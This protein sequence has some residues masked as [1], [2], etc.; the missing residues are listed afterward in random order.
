MDLENSYAGAG[1]I[2]HQNKLRCQCRMQ[3]PG[4]HLQ[5]IALDSLVLRHM[6]WRTLAVLCLADG[7]DGPQMGCPARGNCPQRM[8]SSLYHLHVLCHNFMCL[9]YDLIVFFQFVH[10]KN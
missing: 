10:L 8:H 3:I 6:R 5:H 4:P 7:A 1:I 2:R 9:L